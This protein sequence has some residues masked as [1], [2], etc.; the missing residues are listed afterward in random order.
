MAKTSEKHRKAVRRWQQNNPE[1]H[2][3]SLRKVYKT[4]RYKNKKRNERYMKMYGIT[5]DDYNEL[6]IKQHNVCAIC[7][8]AETILDYRTNQLRNLAVDHCH[9]TG[10]VRGLLCNSCNNMLGRSNDDITI[11]AN[12]IEYL[13][14]SKES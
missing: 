5:L 12:A 1:K 13:R 7:K 10:K 6:A 8:Q 3:E 14:N 9:A 4:D 2:L 11:L